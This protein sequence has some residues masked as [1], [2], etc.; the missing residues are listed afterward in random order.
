VH[1][2][3]S[4]VHKLLVAL[5]GMLPILQVW[6]FKIDELTCTNFYLCDFDRYN[7]LVFLLYGDVIIFAGHPRQLLMWCSDILTSN[8]DLRDV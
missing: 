5:H 1:E 4:H 6:Y 2:R 8:I 7:P 3:D